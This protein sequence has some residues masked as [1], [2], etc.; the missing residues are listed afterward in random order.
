MSVL[1]RE[2]EGL[3]SNLLELST[4]VESGVQRAVKAMANKDPLI[5]QE[6]IDQDVD[7][8]AIE[9]QIEEEC[10]K[11]LALHQPVATDLRFV[12]AALKINNDLER[13]G[14]LAVNVAQ[15]AKFLSKQNVSIPFDFAKMAN[16]VLTMVRDSI[17]A[18][19]HKDLE[20]ANSVLQLDDAV[21]LI[22][23]NMYQQVNAGIRKNPNES[24][25]MISYLS[26]SRHLER[27]AD[28]AT[29]IAED[30]IYMIDGNIIRHLSPS[31]TENV[32]QGNS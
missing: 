26:V 13:M 19:I 30:V 14:D 15:R 3:K 6:V 4:M 23:R 5:A 11:I 25:A 32:L 10:L 16:L 27:I 1:Q 18:L 2:L 20:L 28:Y 7:I 31:E 12:I 9:V 22:N 21:D 17:N 24:E 8:D 29:N